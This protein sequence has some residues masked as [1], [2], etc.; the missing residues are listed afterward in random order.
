[1]SE[2]VAGWLRAEGHAVR[3]GDASA[4]A[5]RLVPADHDAAFLAASLH[6][7]RYQAALVDYARRHHAVL[8]TM[9]SGFISVSLSAAGVDRR[10]WEGL[11]QC[12]ERFRHDTMW[13]SDA[14]HQAAGAIRYRQYGLFTRFAI[15]FIARRRGR[16]TTLSRDYDFTDYNVLK[17]FVLDFIR[18]ARS[19]ASPN[20]R[21]ETTDG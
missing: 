15:W 14:V 6:I 11:D 8:N 16:P 13:R 9:R 10:D 1:L 18:G 12:L 21:R 4:D 5:A 2:R 7:G 19:G 20:P 3:I 17:E